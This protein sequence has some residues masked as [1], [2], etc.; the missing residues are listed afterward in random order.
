MFHVE[1]FGRFGAGANCSTWNNSANGDY[2]L[3]NCFWVHSMVK[4]GVDQA[5][6]FGW[7]LVEGGGWGSS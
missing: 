3:S 5:A 2:L 7:C 1:H 4:F 6:G